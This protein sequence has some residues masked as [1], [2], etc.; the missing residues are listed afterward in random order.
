MSGQDETRQLLR[1]IPSVEALL[2]EPA[3]ARFTE[4]MDRARLRDHLRR[5][6]GDLRK[7]I[8]EGRWNHPGETI[9]PEIVRRL[10][11]HIALVHQPSLRR[12]IN[13]TGVVIHTNLGRA[14]LAEE[15]V[16]AMVDVARHYANLEYDLSEGRRGRRDVHCERW[17]IELLGCQAALVVN[18]CAAAVLLTLNTLAEGGEVIVSRGELVEIGGSFRIPDI[19][20]K[21]GAIL[22]EVG[23]TNRTRLSDYE[24]AINENTRLLLRVHQSN[25][26]ITGFTEQPPLDELVRLGRQYGLPCYHDLG[27]G[28]L[29]DVSAWGIHDE[30]RV[31]DSL[32][33]GVSLCSFSGDKLLGGPQ[34][35]VIVGER[36]LVDRLRRN[37]L[38]RTVR[39]D[40]LTL[41]AL[42]A[43]LRL[44]YSGR[45]ETE[46]PVLSMLRSPVDALRRRA[47]RFIRRGRQ[48]CPHIRFHLRPGASVPGGGT[49]PDARVETVLI[50]VDVPSFPADAVEQRLRAH[51]PPILARIE[52]DRVVLDLR[53]V[54]PDE[55]RTILDAFAAMS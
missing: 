34:A 46:V 43:T 52:D 54:R 29:V 11:D 16:E 40:K 51:D 32:R 10:R 20:A 48:L 5:I 1:A 45:A 4:R 9:V 28:C 7:D 18:N 3:I 27:G 6:L 13:A 35:G 53:T 41:A 8:Q 12:L 17:L 15:A 19:M 38:M 25:F 36:A 49:A 42:E 33:A 24:N 21:S 22:R 55:E 2:N 30:P 47:R 39:P 26:R 14:P 23:T 50:A 31:Q 37:P 44:Y